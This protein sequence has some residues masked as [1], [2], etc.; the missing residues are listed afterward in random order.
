LLF[1]SGLIL[2]LHKVLFKLEENETV[3]MLQNLYFAWNILFCNEQTMN[4]LY[5]LF[6][7]NLNTETY[8]K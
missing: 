5:V 1:N 4:V 7:K 2:K 3:V 8:K 6:K